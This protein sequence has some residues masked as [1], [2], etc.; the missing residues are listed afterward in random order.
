[1]GILISR[2][3]EVKIGRRL[4]ELWRYVVNCAVLNLE[5]RVR[6]GFERRIDYRRQTLEVWSP[7]IVRGEVLVP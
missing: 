6:R 4:L 3:N 5:R 2:G 7:W 1:M